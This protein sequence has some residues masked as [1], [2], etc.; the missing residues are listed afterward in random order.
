MKIF[1]TG[2]TGFLGKRLV[3][4]LVQDGHE[5]LGLA[6]SEA[7]A[8][9]LD[10]QGVRA[11]RGSM[12]SVAEWEE[13]LQG[14]DV[15]VHCAA[16]VEM[17]GEWENYFRQNTLAAKT[18]LE[19]ANRQGVKRFVHISSESV[20]Q[21]RDPLVDIDE[22]LPYPPEPNSY[23]GKSKLLAEQEMRKH[24]G[25]ITCIILRPTFIYGPNDTFSGTLRELVENKK[26]TWVDHGKHLFERVHVDNVVEAI[27]CSLENGRH[28]EAYFITDGAPV[29]VREHFTK[30]A[31][32]QGIEL[33]ERNLPGG[34]AKAVAGLV[35]GVWKLLRLKSAP[36]LSRFEV[37]FVAM[38]RRYRIEKAVRE[39]GY[40]PVHH[41]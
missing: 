11:V 9:G 8:A 35:E 25:D 38:P 2:G 19:A 41:R 30:V 21:D 17:W 15:V 32:E 23:Y 1:V 34:V 20:L 13:Q 7:S 33:P 27:V 40:Q 16:M 4:R 5:V 37:A 39:L 24:Q 26:F 3:K 10:K 31:R 14:I 12:E 29:T 36:P 18:L 22:T 6:R 28:Q